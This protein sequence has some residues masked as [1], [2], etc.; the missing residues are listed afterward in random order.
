MNK[1]LCLIFGHKKTYN[2]EYSDEIAWCDRCDY[3]EYRNGKPFDQVFVQGIAPQLKYEA[4]EQTCE[5]CGI[6]TTFWSTVVR[7]KEWEAWEKVAEKQGFDVHESAETGAFSHNHWDA[8]V[9]FI[10]NTHNAENSESVY[11]GSAWQTNPEEVPTIKDFVVEQKQKSY[12]K[13]ITHAKERLQERFKCVACAEGAKNL[14]HTLICDA[15][16]VIDKELNKE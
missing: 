3:T 16:S 12:R 2:V 14:S 4:W 11:Q 10:R 5:G 7:S 1:I 13:G 6:H 15:I 8:F 9:K